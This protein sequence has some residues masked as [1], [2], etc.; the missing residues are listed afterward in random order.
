MQMGYRKV[1]LLAFAVVVSRF[2]CSIAFTP[3][4]VV[5]ARFNQLTA[6]TPSTMDEYATAPVGMNR[7]LL[8]RSSDMQ[9]GRRPFLFWAPVFTAAAIIQSTT[10]IAADAPALLPL[11]P[12]MD[13]AY[14]FQ[15]SIPTGWSESTRELS[16]DRRK[17]VLFIDPTDSSGQTSLFVAYTPVTPDFT[18][19]GSFGDV[20]SVGETT[21]LPKGEMMGISDTDGR[22][23]SAKSLKS[24]YIYDYEVKIGTQPKRHL[25]TIFALQSAT[26]VEGAPQSGSMLVTI[27]AQTTDDNYTRV[28]ELFDKIIDSYDK[29]GR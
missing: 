27:T 5:Y 22:I 13:R 29:A 18:S 24:A 19:L 6:V 17:L 1:A 23:L 2:G 16:G 14:N 20:A 26:P 12:Y 25:R 9:R 10:A 8:C 7:E 21:I 15:I 3:P 11:S 4:A 28:R